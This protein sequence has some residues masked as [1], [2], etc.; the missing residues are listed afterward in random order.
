MDTS[1]DSLSAETSPLSHT[2]THY[3]FPIENKNYSP[4]PSPSPSP[5]AM[6]RQLRQDLDREF[7]YFRGN[8][9]NSNRSSSDCNNGL[10]SSPPKPAGS[11]PMSGP[12]GLFLDFDASVTRDG[13]VSVDPPPDYHESPVAATAIFGEGDANGSDRYK[14]R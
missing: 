14:H 12:G 13:Y 10:S 3:T 8:G 1:P 6:E 2:H 4:S 7:K 5:D 9:N 11:G